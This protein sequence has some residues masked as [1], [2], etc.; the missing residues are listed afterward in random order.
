MYVCMYLVP[1]PR[2]HLPQTPIKLVLRN[3]G[4]L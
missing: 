4:E 2:L 1:P 3:L